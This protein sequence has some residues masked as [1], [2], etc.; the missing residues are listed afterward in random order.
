MGRARFADRKKQDMGMT[1]KITLP[2]YGLCCLLLALAVAAGAPGTARAFETKAREA[3]LVDYDTGTVLFQKNADQPMPPASMSKMMTVF[4][5]F[6]QLRDGRL[7]LDDKVTVS[8]NA[9]KKGGAASGGSTMFLQPGSEVT[10]EDLLHGIIVQSGNDACIVVAE[11]LAGSEEAFAEAMTKRAHELGL[12][13]SV[14]KNATGLP[15]EGHVSTARDLALLAIHTINEFPEYYKEFYSVKDFTYNGI[16]QGN[17]NPLLYKNVGADGL[18]TG[19]TNAA[20]YG[21]T[22]SAVQDGRRLV[23]VIGGLGSAKERSQEAEQLMAWGFRDFENVRIVEAGKPITDAEVWLGE[24]DTV[25]LTTDRD[26]LVTVFRKAR[27]AME[28]KVKYDGPLPAPIRA[29]DPV[30]TL[31]VTIPGEEPIRTP[32]VAGADVERL[33]FV[34]RIGAALEALVLGQL[35]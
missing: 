30:A 5:L 2:L 13:S 31:V 26:F 32:L 33:G 23:L 29:G 17:R 12:E 9:W 11:A 16:A 20:G 14:F 28:V 21:L 10:I 15:D 8:G 34:G 35:Q 1:R 4:M 24:A 22:A 27:D 18:K 25:P 19:H 6:E 7:K 3:I